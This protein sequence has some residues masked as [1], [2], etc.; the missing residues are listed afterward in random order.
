MTQYSATGHASVI[1]ISIRSIRV[2]EAWTATFNPV[3][4][5]PHI[6]WFATDV[7]EAL[8]TLAVPSRVVG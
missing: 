2:V 4:E 7:A 8:A 3:L 1:P 6:D 5:V